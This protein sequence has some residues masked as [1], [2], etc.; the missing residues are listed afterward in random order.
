MNRLRTKRF[1][2][3]TLIE[4]LVVIAIIAILAGMLLPA[5][6]KA[7]ARAQRINCVNNLKNVGLANRIF[8]TDNGGRF[9]WTVSTNEGG[10]SE[11]LVNAKQA[12]Y[13]YRHFMAISNELSNPK[14]INCPSDSATPKK[15]VAPNFNALAGLANQVDTK[16]VN[17]SEVKFNKGVSYFIGLTASEENP[18]TVLGGDRNITLD[19]T[20]KTIELINSKVFATLTLKQADVT[21]DVSKLKSGYDNS[22]HTG[23]GNLLLGDGSV[24]QVTS[25]R[26]KEALR[27]AFNSAG[28]IEIIAPNNDGVQ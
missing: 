14:I 4:L 13:V 24:Q 6:A 16:G 25:G 28:N 1:S 26:L 12:Q 11:W 27:D 20:A 5:L 15:A 17:V 7:K 23:A 3:F 19:T 8:S 2:A 10:S 18:Q 22:T 21:G 9:T